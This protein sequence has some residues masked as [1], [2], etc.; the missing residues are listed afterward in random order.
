M[1]A[2]MLLHRACVQTGVHTGQCGGHGHRL[3][4][5]IADWRDDRVKPSAGVGQRGGPRANRRRG[6][7]CAER[8]E[9]QVF[10]A[11]RLVAGVFV[12]LRRVWKN[13]MF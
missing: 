3:V 10:G 5:V 11:R 4:L 9:E 12:K 1:A 13:V 2:G 6:V 8:F 7:G